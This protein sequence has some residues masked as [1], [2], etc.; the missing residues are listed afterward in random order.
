MNSSV[1]QDTGNPPFFS[2]SLRKFIVMSV[3]TLTMYQFYWFYKQWQLIRLRERSNISPVARTLFT[4][5][6]C[7]SCFERIRAY[8]S[9]SPNA[10]NVAA[11]PLAAAWIVSSLMWYMP[12]PAFLLGM[13]S[14][15]ALLPVQAEANRA[16]AF[17]A[18]LHDRNARF[19]PVN[20]V[21]IVIG[22]P[23]FALALIGAFLVPK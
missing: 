23:L 19:T 4:F 10:Q 18:P 14:P 8:D 6:Y 12:E 3:C 21:A 15:L 5:F 9:T 7:Y 11:A 13:L 17:A 16:N 2:V 22:G 1:L 20:W